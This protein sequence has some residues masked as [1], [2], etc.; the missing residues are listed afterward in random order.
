ME[1]DKIR[2]K[3]YVETRFDTIIRRI[4]FFWQEITPKRVGEYLT[5]LKADK[6]AMKKAFNVVDSPFNLNRDYITNF[7][8]AFDNDILPK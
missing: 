2:I 4:D 5:Q 6:D 3:R 7:L 8:S 1:E